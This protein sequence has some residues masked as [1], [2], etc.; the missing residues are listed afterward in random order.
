MSHPFHEEVTHIENGDVFVSEMEFDGMVVNGED[1]DEGEMGGMVDEG[2]MGGVV[3]GGEMG[4]VVDG[5][6]IG[7][8]VDGGVLGGLIG[9]VVDGGVI[10]GVVDGGEVVLSEE[11]VN[12]GEMVGNRGVVEESIEGGVA[13]GGCKDAERSG[14]AVADLVKSEKPATAKEVGEELCG[15]EGVDDAD[16]DKDYQPTHGKFAENKYAYNS[17]G[18]ADKATRRDSITDS[19]K[20]S[21]HN[22]D[23]DDDEDDDDDDDDGDDDDDDDE[24]DEEEEFRF[25]YRKGSEF[26]SQH[27]F[28]LFI[29]LFIH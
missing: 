21:K 23:D 19:E 15:Y 3:D 20:S 6:E 1:V 4:G 26:K 28:E 27:C 5:G 8:V 22:D 9:G 7:V 29:Y 24:D 13:E 25:S 18:R 17:Y 16:D 11:V 10:G 2:E 12:E 14:R